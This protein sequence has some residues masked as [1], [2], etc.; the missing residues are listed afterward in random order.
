MEILMN[1]YKQIDMDLMNLEDFTADTLQ[2]LIENEV[3]ENVHLDY[4]AALRSRR[5]TEAR[6]R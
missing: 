1:S 5:M 2:Y 3:E 6:M 4:K